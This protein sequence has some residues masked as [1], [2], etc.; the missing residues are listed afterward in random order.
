MGD[1]IGGIFGGLG[2]IAGAKIQSDAQK[3]AIKAQQDALKEQIARLDSIDAEALSQQAAAADIA[4]QA[5]ALLAQ[6]QVDPAVAAVR[7]IGAQQVAAEALRT[8][9]PSDVIGSQLLAESQTADPKLQALK[10]S[11]LDEAKAELEAGA[12]LP[13][14]FQAE[15]IRSGLESGG[16]AGIGVSGQG[17]GGVG[18]RQLVGR[19]GLALRAQR[20]AQAANL[21]STAQNIETARLN[22]LSSILPTLKNVEGADFAQAAN[23]FQLGQSTVSP[24]GLTGESIVDI[25][26][27]KKGAQSQAT[28]A[29]GK[30]AAEGALQRGA[31]INQLIGQGVGLAQ[32]TIS[33]FSK[34]DTEEQRLK[35]KGFL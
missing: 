22:V 18:L 4:R 6:R 3:K 9:K 13:P 20:Q 19:E 1:A 25:E 35:R 2:A 26:L 33:A 27:A 15:L 28:A 11:L 7:A 10:Q 17:A 29:A 31:F 12:T 8:G 32:S 16:R 14:D 23:T 24:A 34:P 21:A 5:N 30:L